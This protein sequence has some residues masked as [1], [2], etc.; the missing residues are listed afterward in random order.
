MGGGFVDSLSLHAWVPSPPT[1]TIAWQPMHENKPQEV[2]VVQQVGQGTDL[3]GMFIIGHTTRLRD[4]NI[5]ECMG[6]VGT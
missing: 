6:W 4:T 1:A 2:Q 3:D 5:I